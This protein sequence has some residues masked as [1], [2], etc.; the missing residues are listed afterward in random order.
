MVADD[1]GVRLPCSWEYLRSV[2]SITIAYSGFWLQIKA[3]FA[4][5]TVPSITQLVLLLLKWRS[6]LR[7]CS[8]HRQHPKPHGTSPC[9]VLRR[10]LHAYPMSLV[11]L[12]QHRPN[13]IFLISAQNHFCVASKLK[14]NRVIQRWSKSLCSHWVANCVPAYCVQYIDDQFC[15]C[16]DLQHSYRILYRFR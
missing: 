9:V 7:K 4:I 11:L 5:S 12:L 8:Y 14:I 2:L 6:N 16:L 10:I 3:I 15:L 13:D 1:R